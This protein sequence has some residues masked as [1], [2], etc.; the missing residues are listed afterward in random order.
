EV[1]ATLDAAARLA[2]SG[3]VARAAERYLG[4]LAQ[5]PPA[6]ENVALARR[7]LV[8]APAAAPQ[9]KQQAGVR[10]WLDWTLDLCLGAG[11]P[12]PAEAIDR[13][14]GR[15]GDLPPATRALAALFGGRPVAEQLERSDSDLG[16][17][18]WSDYLIARARS[19]AERGEVGEAFS[20]LARVHSS[21]TAD[22][23][24]WLAR[25]DVA[26]A[27]GDAQDLDLAERELGGLA[28][29]RWRAADWALP[30]D[31]SGAATLHFFAR[32]A[33]KRLSVVLEAPVTGAAVEVRLDGSQLA[34]A[35]VS[36]RSELDLAA[37]IGA[38]VHRLEVVSRG[39]GSVS[40]SDVSL[41]Y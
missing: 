33:A 9:V 11:C 10:A 28:R 39:G 34:L 24:Y 29:E 30:A 41:G 6:V 5:L 22:P 13:L 25:R 2:R 21:A 35:I 8:E 17:P 3:N 19:Q 7:V 16:A 26:R 4:V 37:P 32:N 1:A 14:R 12:L 18:A 27:A 20:T 40:P 36:E 38:G 31:R 23:V 15:A